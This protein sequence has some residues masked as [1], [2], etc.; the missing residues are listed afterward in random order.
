M[1]LEL[2]DIDAK[3]IAQSKNDLLSPHFSMWELCNNFR[4]G[5]LEAY[6]FLFG[7]KFRAS[8][9]RLC[10]EQLEPL[11]KAFASPIHINSGGRWAQKT[12]PGSVYPWEG[13]DVEIRPIAKRKLYEPNSQH[14]RFEA[15]DIVIAGY[16]PLELVKWIIEK[17]PFP[18]GQAINEIGGRSSWLHISIPGIRLNGESIFCEVLDAKVLSNGNAVYSPIK[19]TKRF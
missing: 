7:A 16:E 15:A 10:N 2:K 11:R 14:T 18:W 17:A 4:G 1:T 6:N 8:L 9:V 19:F 13:L 3:F 12:K 5:G